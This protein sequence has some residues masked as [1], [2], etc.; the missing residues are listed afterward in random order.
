MGRDLSSRVART[1]QANLLD[2]S[3]GLC[4]QYIRDCSN[5]IWNSSC[6]RLFPI[7]TWFIHIKI[8]EQAAEFEIVTLKFCN[9]KS[10]L[11]ESGLQ[12]INT[13]KGMRHCHFD[14][15][16][17]GN[18]L[19]RARFMPYNSFLNI[20]QHLLKLLDLQF[21]QHPKCRRLKARSHQELGSTT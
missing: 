14:R 1:K 7:H 18:G 8:V 11:T 3:L 17:K 12:P 2:G 4:A 19:W 15:A 13:T 16:D 21:W 9:T 10:H 6:R 20:H 5:T